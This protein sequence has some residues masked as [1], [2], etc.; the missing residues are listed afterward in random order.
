[1]YILGIV[2]KSFFLSSIL[3]YKISE[4]FLDITYKFKNH[5]LMIFNRTVFTRNLCLIS[6]PQN[7]SVC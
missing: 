2:H 3:F 6:T 1:M 5:F 4:P 7:A